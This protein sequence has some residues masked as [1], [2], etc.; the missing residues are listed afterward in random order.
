MRNRGA[1]GR[2]R[3]L[4][5]PTEGRVPG[6]P[7]RVHPVDADGRWRVVVRHCA[8]V[9]ELRDAQR[10]AETVA[11]GSWS[12]PSASARTK[13]SWLHRGPAWTRRYR[14]LK[15]ARALSSCE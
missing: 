1:R 5:A 10:I 9:G 14:R 4:F 7:H 2:K 3:D 8:D 13:N 11:A 12:L 6:A 15:S